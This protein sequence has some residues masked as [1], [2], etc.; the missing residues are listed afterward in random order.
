MI[1]IVYYVYKIFIHTII[2]PLMEK[3]I[4]VE[5]A[6]KVY[7]LRGSPGQGL[8]A[9]TFGFFMGFTAVA[10]YGPIAK[11]LR[12]I[13]HLPSV[14]V[15]L[16]VAIPPLTGSLLRIPFGA[17]TDKVGGRRPM[18]TL[19]LL[20]IVGMSGLTAL[21]FMFY[22]HGLTLEMYPLI[23]LFGALA[24]CGVATFAVGV[25]QTSYWF[26]KRRQGFALGAYAGLGNTAPG[27][28]T[29]LV[30]LA[31]AAVG[32]PG[33]Y[34]IWLATLATG[35]AVY[36]IIARDAYYFQ[37]VNHGVPRDEAIRI[38]RGLGQELFPTGKLVESLRVSAKLVRT[39]ALVLLY[40]VSFGGFLALTAWFPTYWRELHG[41]DMVTAG[42]LA[43]AGFTLTASFIRVVGGYVS[44]RIGG[45][46]TAILS[47]LVMLL[48]AGLL[49]A[50]TDFFTSL[51][52]M[53]LVA[54]GAGVANAAV[55][56]LVPKYVPEAVGGATG[57]VGG[58]GAFGGF[59][60]PPVLGLFVDLMGRVGYARGFVTYVVLALISIVISHI[61]SKKYGKI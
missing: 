44:D 57:W 19:L 35:T 13:M 42:V 52:G 5:E 36:Y 50:S 30:P 31:V 54:S 25:P 34:A 27:F 37:L 23:L 49:T 16:M 15:G 43:G 11:E 55:F 45:E 14:L 33:A 2:K 53:V 7:R 28:F 32:L 17:W 60:I 8:A 6:K 4:S 18:L 24:G 56:K 9:A 10:L 12:D 59:A 41:L 20:S 40:F 38:A 26:P 29:L 51:V 22:P 39:W 61:L 3:A 47:Y 1:Y 48:G 21:L 58:L 46:R